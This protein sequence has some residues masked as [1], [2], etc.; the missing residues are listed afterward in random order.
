[1]FCEEVWDLVL[2]IERKLKRGEKKCK[3]Q[4]DWVLAE[5]AAMTLI[6]IPELHKAPI[7]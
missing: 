1:V 7:I 3:W 4:K 5:L 6:P 2:L